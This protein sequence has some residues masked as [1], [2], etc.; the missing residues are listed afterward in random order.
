MNI[1]LGSEH[2]NSPYKQEVMLLFP[3]FQFDPHLQVCEQV[4]GLS[5]SGSCCIQFDLE[6]LLSF[7]Q[8][9]DLCLS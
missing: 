7:P 6:F 3:E 8:T 4:A 5:D 9:A 2:S 1:S